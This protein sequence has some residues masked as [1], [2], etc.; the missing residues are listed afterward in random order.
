LRLDVTTGPFPTGRHRN[1]RSRDTINGA[2][3]RRW[4]V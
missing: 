1:D 3:F 4:K 2:T